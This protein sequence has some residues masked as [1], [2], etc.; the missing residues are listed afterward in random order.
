MAI[1]QHGSK[2]CHLCLINSDHISG[3]LPFQLF[4]VLFFQCVS[5]RFFTSQC[6][7]VAL[8]AQIVGLIT[9]FPKT[10]AHICAKAL[11]ISNRHFSKTISTSGSIAFSLQS[12]SFGWPG[13]FRSRQVRIFKIWGQL[14]SRRGSSDLAKQTGHSDVPRSLWLSGG[15]VE[16]CFGF[17]GNP[18]TASSSFLEVWKIDQRRVL[19]RVKKW[20][21]VTSQEKFK[22]PPIDFV[23]F[24]CLLTS[25]FDDFSI[26]LSPHLL[27]FD[28]FSF[29]TVNFAPQQFG[30]FFGISKARSQDL[31]N[32]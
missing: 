32:R 3:D 21:D 24:C 23:D 14:L 16:R 11:P 27:L 8:A 25:K 12:G 15:P 1:S 18:A 20:P 4:G 30:A 17:F 22:M 2:V 19:K 6:L 31:S 7:G 13:T 29:F 28:D 5:K 10:F 9:I 26:L